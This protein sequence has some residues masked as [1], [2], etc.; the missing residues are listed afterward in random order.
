ME[1]RKEAPTHMQSR[2]W[3]EEPEAANPFAARSSHCHGYDVFG[4]M[5]GRAGWAEMIYLLFRGEAPTAPQAAAMD[6]LAVALA[7]PGP[8]DASVHAAMCGGVGGSPAAAS[9]IAALAVGAGS[10]GGSREILL[11][12][13]TWSE[14]GTDLE[15]WNRRLARPVSEPISVWPAMEHPPGFDPHGI[16]TPTP[17]KQLLEHLARALTTGESASETS[18]NPASHAANEAKAAKPVKT[19]WLK[20]NLQSLETL[21]GRPLSMAGAAAAGF[22]DL[23]FSPQEGEML[24]LMLRLPGAAAHA[25]EQSAYGHKRFPFYKMELQDGPTQRG[26]KAA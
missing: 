11:A 22:A 15:A 14:C 16:G 20:A 24:Y 6:V 12:M 8:R 10:L 2:I 4:D 26:G 1:E 13:E 23:G 7:N 5:L 25:L 18:A 3:L 21:A 17:V 19:A 9:L